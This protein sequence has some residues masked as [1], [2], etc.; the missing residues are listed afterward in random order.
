MVGL[1]VPSNE[2]T[3]LRTTGNASQSPFTI[4]VR[5]TGT[6][7]VPSVIDAVI[8]TPAWSAGDPDPLEGSTVFDGLALAGHAPR[9]FRCISQYGILPVAVTLFGVFKALV[10]MMLSRGTSVSRG[11][12]TL[13]N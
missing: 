10:N 8:L 5:R 4:A 13:V 7:V 6:N 12:A 2:P 3:L 11:L 1:V 9:G